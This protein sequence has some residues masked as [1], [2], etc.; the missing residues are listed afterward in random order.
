MN[1]LD[2]IIEL[3]KK[4]NEANQAY[5][6]FDQP[7]ISDYEY[8]LLLKELITLEKQYPQYDDPHSPSKQIG[9]IILEGFSKVKHKTAMMSLSNAFSLAEL[10]SFY[11]KI[12]QEFSQ[13]EYVAELKIDGLAINLTYQQGKLITAS[14]RGNGLVGEDVTLNIKQINSIPKTLTKPIDIEVRGEVYMPRESFEQLNQQR[15]NNN[16]AVFANPRNAAA[17]TI[18]QLDSRVVKARNLSAFVYTI[19]DAQNYVKTQQ[20]ALMFLKELG[21]LVN[22]DYR[23]IKTFN[24]LTNVINEFDSLR[25]DLVYDTDGVVIKVNDF[26]LYE[27]IGYI[28]KAP[29]WAIAYKFAPEEVITQVKEIICQVGRTGLITPVANLEPVLVSGSTVSRAT[30]H[31]EDFIISKDIRVGDYVVIRKAGEIIPEV[32]SVIQERRTN[33]VPFIMTKVCPMCQQ[34]LSR[35]VD[36]ADY[37]CLNPHCEGRNITGL[38]HFASRVCMDIDGLGE[39]LIETL[40]EEK[41]LNNITDIYLLHQQADRLINLEGFGDKKVNNLLTAIENS[42]QQPL[43]RLVF[44]L[45]IKHVGAKVAKILVNKYASMNALSQAQYEDLVVID[46]IGEAIATSLVSYFAN[47]FHLELIQNLTNLGLNMQSEIKEVKP[48]VFN[49]LTFVITGTLPTLSRNEASELIESLG[50]KVSSSVSKKTDYVLAG[51]E[52]GSKLTKASELKIKIINEQQFKELI[53]E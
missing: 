34:P 53:N 44:G 52:A 9:H 28:A 27:E 29:K 51:A 42:K 35:Q 46:E 36:Q 20:Q 33:Q 11:H 39:K 25:K 47:P 12:N 40:Y 24:D 3:R 50:A 30:L 10:E 4:I 21:F 32:V 17:G 31:N 18:R 5:H 19:V 7:V 16:E 15:L 45:G 26:S 43:E 13:T 22:P 2:K 23:L 1:S 49:G 8:D 6:T 14:T 48:H 37:F 41:F 38:I